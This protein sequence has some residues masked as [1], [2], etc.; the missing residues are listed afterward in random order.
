MEQSTLV[1]AVRRR[2]VLQGGLR[3]GLALAGFGLMARPGPVH[4]SGSGAGGLALV[5]GV[6]RYERARDLMTPVAD[7]QAVAQ[8]L[9]ALGYGLFGGG[10]HADPD[11]ATYLAL[12][13]AFAAAVPSGG[14]AF[15]YLAGHGVA[16]GGVT[17]LVPSNDADLLTRHD[18]DERAVALPVLTARLAARADVASFIFLDACRANGLRRE[19]GP[20]NGD[21]LGGGGDLVAPGRG[22][23]TLTYAAAPGQIAADGNGDGG[24]GGDGAGGILSPFAA[25]L[26]HALEMPDRSPPDF[27]TALSGQTRRLTHGAQTPFQMQVLAGL[28]PTGLVP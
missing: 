3:A 10:V 7:A 13:R 18:L 22:A 27:F 21:A 19:G 1:R 2:E 6:A 26:L 11:R 17:Y 14:H 4:A 9:Q 28:N 23:M 15:V 12:L 5:V 24:D 25:A 8:R 16:Q 20:V